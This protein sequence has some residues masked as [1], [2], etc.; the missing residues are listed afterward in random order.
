MG[1]PSKFL[2]EY[3][4]SDDY[5]IIKIPQ[6]IKEILGEIVPVPNAPEKPIEPKKPILTVLPQPTPPK[7]TT[8]SWFGLDA[9]YKALMRIYERNIEEHPK[10]NKQFEEYYKHELKLYEK[11]ME[12]YENEVLVDYQ[13]NVESYNHIKK[14]CNSG[15]NDISSRY[16]LLYIYLHFNSSE[17]S[18]CPANNSFA[19]GVAESYF[20]KFLTEYYNK[21]LISSPSSII[22]E[23]HKR[24][25]TPDFIL[26]IDNMY[27]DIEI[28]EPYVAASYKPTH[29]LEDLNE[30]KRNRSRNFIPKN[31]QHIDDKRDKFFLANNWLVVRFTERQVV[32]S[33]EAC[34]RVLDELVNYVWMRT[35]LRQNL[36]SNTLKPEPKWT[37]YSAMGLADKQYRQS[38]LPPKLAQSVTEARNAYL[39]SNP[40]YHDDDNNLPF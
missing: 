23:G 3:L 8:L 39:K 36:S 11:L 10:F 14:L 38:Y 18:P 35:E 17:A 28:D 13:C 26:R 37:E 34:I 24:F 29:F 9:E 5:P 31:L 22:A 2:Q 16:E 20:K 30:K 6:R 7:K 33:P 40:Q 19:K 4:Q 1:H 32:E 15:I 12:Q 25:Y 21:D 27:I